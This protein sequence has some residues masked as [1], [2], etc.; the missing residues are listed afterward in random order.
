MRKT[1]KSRYEY[2]I[3]KTEAK[4]EKLNKKEELEDAIVATAAEILATQEEV[5]AM[6]AARVAENDVFLKAKIQGSVNLVQ[7]KAAVHG[8]RTT[9]TTRPSQGRGHPPGSR[10]RSS[11]SSRG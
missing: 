11:R 10:R 9:R 1:A 3:E 4:I 7:V 6:E 8:L 5:Q 2:K